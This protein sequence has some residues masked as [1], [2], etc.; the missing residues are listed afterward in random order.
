MRKTARAEI[1]EWETQERGLLVS[2]QT[3]SFCDIVSLSRN[4]LTN[5]LPNILSVKRD[6][7]KRIYENKI[8]ARV[9][10][11]EK[12]DAERDARVGR[13]T[14]EKEKAIQEARDVARRA[15]HVLRQH[16]ADRLA[17]A[18][19]AVENSENRERQDIMQGEVI[20]IYA[21]HGAAH[22]GISE[23]RVAAAKRIKWEAE[24]Y[25][26]EDA[27][28]VECAEK[29]KRE[30]AER[31]VVLQEESVKIR[32]ACTHGRGGMSNLTGSF[33]KKL[34][35]LCKVH[36]DNSLGVYVRDK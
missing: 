28:K 24:A 21:F 4:L 15:Q 33:G 5:P 14:Y 17:R 11:Y 10:L 2:D 1:C 26:R 25:M 6:R 36:F 32:A 23:A 18:K 3:S 13:E 20:A 22:A 16:A 19:A 29:Q 30:E 9:T 8:E 27:Y 35:R 12:N 34:C 7:F 31:L